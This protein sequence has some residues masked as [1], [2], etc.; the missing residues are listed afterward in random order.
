MSV[1]F[2]D[3]L[4][5]VVGLD[6]DVYCLVILVITLLDSYDSSFNNLLAD[7]VDTA[8]RVSDLF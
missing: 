5:D 3:W 8:Y 6:Y 4:K 2:V 7:A 1:T